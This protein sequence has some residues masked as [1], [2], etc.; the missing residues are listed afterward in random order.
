M[1][2]LPELECVVGA[3]I[4]EERD[5]RAFQLPVNFHVEIRDKRK[6][7]VQFFF[8]QHEASSSF[9]DHVI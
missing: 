7:I 6:H 3:H 8:V 1:P 5:R 4:G 9:K 2:I